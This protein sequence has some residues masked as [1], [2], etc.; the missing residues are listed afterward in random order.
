MSQKVPQRNRLCPRLLFQLLSDI[1]DPELSLL[2][3]SGILG[4][5][6]DLYGEI[7]SAARASARQKYYYLKRLKKSDAT[8]YWQLF[9]SISEEVNGQGNLLTEEKNDTS[10]TKIQESREGR[11]EKMSFS[12]KSITS[13][14]RKPVGRSPVN[15]MFRDISEAK[16]YGK[17]RFLDRDVKMT[18]NFARLYVNS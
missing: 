13:T 16:T 14:P 9:Q 18:T 6:T 5:R 11:P 8:K 15:R 12:P 17:Y 10:S 2:D 3:I 7:G 1:E 4:N